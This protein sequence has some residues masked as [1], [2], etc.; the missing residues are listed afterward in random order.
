MVI[1][2]VTF[3][4]RS[5]T[6]PKRKFRAQEALEHVQN[7]PT[8][9]EKVN[10]QL[11]VNLLDEALSLHDKVKVV[12]EGGGP[13]KDYRHFYLPK[14]IMMALRD[15]ALCVAAGYTPIIVH[16]NRITSNDAAKLLGCAPRTV[17]DLTDRGLLPFTRTAGGHRRFKLEDINAYLSGKRT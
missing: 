10:S 6:L 1:L 13:T 4:K 16:T 3:T 11:I 17:Q 7:P 12:I 9:I 5:L 15:A 14:C 2:L 8:E